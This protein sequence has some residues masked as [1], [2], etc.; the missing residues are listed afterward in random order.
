[1]TNTEL[2]L[3]AKAKNGS[4]GGSSDAE[5]M[6]KGIIDGTVRELIIPNGVTSIRQYAFYSCTGLTSVTIPNSVTTIGNYVF[7]SCAGLTSVTI[8]NGFNAD[9]LDVSSSTRYSVD[10]LVNMLNALA[11]RTG[12]SAYTLKL[13]SR[14]LGKLSNEQIAIATEKNW[15]LA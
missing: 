6:L 3:Y 14:N 1:M 7:H 8:G 13:G 10:T 9:N 4:G 5:Q 12:L 11:D 2:Y 15:T